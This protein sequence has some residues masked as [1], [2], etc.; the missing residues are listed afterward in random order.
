MG[1]TT[2][3]HPYKGA[4]LK[5]AENLSKWNAWK[6]LGD[7]N[8]TLLLCFKILNQMQTGRFQADDQL[9][10]HIEIFAL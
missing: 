6:R 5:G 9:H 2:A 10:I 1:L 3:Y 4:Q 8:F 7:Y